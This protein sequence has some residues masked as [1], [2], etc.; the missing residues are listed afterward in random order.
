MADTIR[1]FDIVRVVSNDVGG[2]RGG[3]EGTVVDV[4][5]PGVFE[6]EFSDEDGRPY[7]IEPL[8]AEQ[9]KVTI[10]HRPKVQTGGNRFEIYRD[11]NGEWRWRLATSDGR[12]I[13]T[14]GQGY[15]SQD[16]ILRAIEDVRASTL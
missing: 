8:R 1:L 13:A 5:G 10:P 4:L 15:D 6:V 11:T 7:A 14:S 9:L 12:A 16:G 2:V 3:D